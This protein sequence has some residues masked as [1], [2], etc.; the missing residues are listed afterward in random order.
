M[1]VIILLF[2]FSLNYFIDYTLP[3]LFTEETQP[4][5]NKIVN[6]INVRLAIFSSLIVTVFILSLGKI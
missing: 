5:I 1:F 6:L 4:N 2:I 3:V